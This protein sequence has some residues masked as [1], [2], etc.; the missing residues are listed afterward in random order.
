MFMMTAGGLKCA[1]RSRLVAILVDE[2]IMA[3]RIGF[4]FRA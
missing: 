3:A 1:S 4:S 2:F